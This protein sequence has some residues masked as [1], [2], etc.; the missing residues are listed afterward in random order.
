MVVIELE[1][2]PGTVGLDLKPSDV[3][4]SPTECE[5]QSTQL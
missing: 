3:T 4:E 2:V 1:S 5:N